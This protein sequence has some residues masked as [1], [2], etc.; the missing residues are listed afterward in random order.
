MPFAFSFESDLNTGLSLWPRL[1]TV[2]PLPVCYCNAILRGKASDQHIARGK[3]C[4]GL[5]CQLNRVCVD[6]GLIGLSVL[7]VGYSLLFNIM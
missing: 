3:A 5:Y 2:Y 6:C 4:Y 7:I 1:Q